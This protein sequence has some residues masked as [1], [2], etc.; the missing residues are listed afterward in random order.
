MIY[1]ELRSRGYDVG[2][3]K[4]ACGIVATVNQI[5][6]GRAKRPLVCVP[7]A[8]KAN[9][10][11]S[12]HQLFPDIKVNDLGNLSKNYWKE[13]MKIEDGSI[14]V[15]T[16]EGLGNIGFNEAEE[17]EIQEDVEY[18]AMQQLKQSEAWQKHAMKVCSSLIWDLTI[19]QW[20]KFIDSAI[21]SK[22]RAT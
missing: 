13:R 6:T 20:T 7:K 9:W 14:S 19:S 10:I 22:C 8:V 15:C 4:T 1:L 17:A 21:F 11:E 12:I 3:G 16:H 5:Q 18:G 2:V